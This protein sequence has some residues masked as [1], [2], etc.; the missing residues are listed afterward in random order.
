M[1]ATNQEQL[2]LSCKNSI[3]RA[4]VIIRAKLHRA[5]DNTEKSV[6]CKVE[7]TDHN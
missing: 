6:D 7:L 5:T 2:D 3:Y 1:I 4:N